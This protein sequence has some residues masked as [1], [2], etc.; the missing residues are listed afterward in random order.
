M[1]GWQPYS[2]LVKDDNGK[3]YYKAYNRMDPRFFIY[4]LAADLK[5]GVT[6]MNE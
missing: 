5:E 3:F 1:T 4:G 2:I 6:N